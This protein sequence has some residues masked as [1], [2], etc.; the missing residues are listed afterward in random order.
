VTS[1]LR[2]GLLICEDPQSNRGWTHSS[3]NCTCS[4]CF[5]LK[6]IGSARE[7]LPSLRQLSVIVNLTC[8]SRQGNDRPVVGTFAN[9]RPRK[10]ELYRP[11]NPPLL[12]LKNSTDGMVAY[13]GVFC[14]QM[15]LGFFEGMKIEW[16]L[17]R[18]NRDTIHH[19]VENVCPHPRDKCWCI[20]RSID[21]ESLWGLER[22]ITR[23]LLGGLGGS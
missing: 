16:V 5:H 3:P 7:K 12:S 9:G 19:N 20:G 21:E 6:G 10:G 22:E 18:F 23:R 17:V 1:D 2:D 15:P 14:G 11:R 8:G 13:A 4:S